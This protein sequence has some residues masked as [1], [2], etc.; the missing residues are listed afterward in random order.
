MPEPINRKL[1]GL[2]PCVRERFRRVRQRCA[3]A[4]VSLTL[5]ETR[6]S[7]ARQAMLRARGSSRVKRSRHQDGL[8]F[9]VCPTALLKVKGWDTTPPSPQWTVYGRACEAEGLTWG[10]RWRTLVD[11][12]H[13]QLDA[14]QCPVIAR[15]RHK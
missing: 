11:K 3:A 10:G 5:T 15:P 13:A 1:T 14:C 4:G 8:A 6:R 9:D 12:P 2:C 7:A